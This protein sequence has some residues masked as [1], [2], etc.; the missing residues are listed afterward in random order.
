MPKE[1]RDV[2]MN[3]SE[4]AHAT[5]GDE[6]ARLR[7]AVEDARAC[8]RDAERTAE[9]LRHDGYAQTFVE[10]FLYAAFEKVEDAVF[11]LND[12]GYEE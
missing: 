7:K 2:V 6:E 8:V 9:Q 12:A 3:E 11:A 5:M 10:S 1:W 4:I